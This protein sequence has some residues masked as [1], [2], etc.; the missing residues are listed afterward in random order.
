MKLN[1]ESIARASSRHPWRTLVIWLIVFAAAGASSSALLSDALTTDFDFTNTPE[2]KRAIAVLDEVRLEDD[3]ATESFIITA[4]EGTS[5]QDPAFVAHVNDV[6]ALLTEL[7]PD[8]VQ[9]VPVAFPLPDDVAADPQA[10]ALGPI[11]SEDGTAV[12]FTVVMAGDANEATEAIPKI[13]AIAE[14]TSV[15]GATTY[16]I[17]QASST[18]EFRKISEE[19]LAV[20]EGLGILAAIVVLLIVFSAIIG[21]MLPII[22]GV[23]AISVTLGIMGVI[24]QV[25]SFSFFAP[26]L[27]SMMGLAVG[28]DYALFIVS[29]NREER[30]RGLDK[31]EA[32]GRSGATANRAVFFSG[33]TV[34]LA[35]AGMLLVP[36]TIFRSLA[37]GAIIV[38]LVSM[39][40]SMTLLPALLALFGD[41]V[42]WPWLRRGWTI[43][44]FVV[45]AAVAGVIGG[46]LAAAGAPPFLA[47][48]G[49]VAGIVVAGIVLTRYVRGSS[50]ERRRGTQREGDEID[51]KG[52]TLST[53]GGFWDR[54]T[55]QVMGRPVMWLVL[56][57]GFLIALSL[58]YWFQ[59]HPD[60][61][62]RGIKTGL[63]GISSLPDEVQAKQAFNLLISRFPQA[64][65]QS[66]AEV[67]IQGDADE[68]KIAALSEAIA[69]DARFAPPL[70]AITTEDGSVTLVRIPLAGLA[71]DGQNEAAISAIT[72]LRTTYVPEVFGEEARQLGAPNAVLVGGETAFVKDFFDISET[73]TPLIIL[74]VLALSFVLLTIVFR[75]IVVPVKAII[76]NLLSVG[77]AYGL[78]VLVFQQGGPAIGESIAGLFGFQQV[79][80][81][82]SWLPLFLFSIL[83]GLSMDY[84]VFLLT[85]IREEYD[86]TGRNAEAVAFG[87][88]TTGGI[89]TGAAIIM[90]AVFAGFAAGRLTSLE[91]MGFGLAVAV[92]LDATVVRSILV[93]ST[94]RLLGDRNW[95][96]PRWLQW[97]PKID[98]EGHDAALRV[99]VPDSPAELVEAGERGDG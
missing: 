80:A 66:A 53:D 91:Q 32:I 45:L 69:D 15:D 20:G 38:V 1:P 41:W 55:R 86:R 76:M 44:A 22:M 46:G 79:E 30:H 54:V 94:M 85:R 48:L 77:A 37:G 16:F 19:D 59:S 65:L 28:I 61:E 24:G 27:V 12:L 29:R 4:P 72:D 89:I 81:I 90:V 51:A 47:V 70:P 82:E 25:W 88:R 98:V 39:A 74:L 43:L 2:A 8:A 68:A 62:G 60:G 83:F 31:L 40:A 93:P 23:F 73:Y 57:A 9:A 14:E 36:T 87:L 56:A 64:G 7:G 75:S 10:A 52:S 99:E 78:I 5:V 17:G 97:L 42:N 26:N 35:L 50:A 3:L 84:H 34:V 63:A 13:D 21:G 6:L 33:L 67:V 92:L 71:A 18:E 11:A 49:A 96:L 58:P 95:Y